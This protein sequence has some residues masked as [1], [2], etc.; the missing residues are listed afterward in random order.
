[1]LTKAI[2]K[3]TRERKPKPKKHRFCHINDELRKE[4]E[5]EDPKKWVWDEDKQLLYE[6]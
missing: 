2:F 1:M 3:I 6:Q 4:V 5:D